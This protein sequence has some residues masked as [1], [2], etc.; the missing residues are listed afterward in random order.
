MPKLKCEYSVH[1]LLDGNHIN[2]RFEILDCPLT[3][4][5]ISY[6]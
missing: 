5:P 4:L 3:T 2:F 1:L 6:A